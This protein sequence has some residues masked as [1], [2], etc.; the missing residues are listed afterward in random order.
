MFSGCNI[1]IN[2]LKSG[3]PNISNNWDKSSINITPSENKS[4]STRTQNFQF[5]YLDILDKLQTQNEVEVAV[6]LEDNVNLSCYGSITV[7]RPIYEKKK[8][9]Y[10]TA[11]D[12]VLST[13]SKDDFRLIAKG[14]LDPSFGGF[15]TKSGLEKLK[16][17]PKVIDIQPSKVVEIE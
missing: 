14:T 3:S 13:L 2:D 16:L 1:D 5:N 10:L 12:E 15:I 7:C 4:I 6:I 8:Q 11:E 17:N 9:H